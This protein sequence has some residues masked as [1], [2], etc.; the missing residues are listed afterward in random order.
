[1]AIVLALCGRAAALNKDQVLLLVNANMPESRKLAEFYCAARQIPQERIVALPL[2]I[3]EEIGYAAYEEQL[4]GPLREYI[5]ARR[6][7]NEIACIV[8]FHGVP[9][10]IGARTQ[11]P[12]ERQE[13]A[14]IQRQARALQPELASQVRDLET[15]AGGDPQFK[16]AGG[17][18][19]PEALLTRARAAALSLA[20]SPD[21]KANSQK[22][23]PAVRQLLGTAGVVSYFS[24]PDDVD[25]EGLRQQLVRSAREADAFRGNAEDAEARLRLRA[26][27]PRVFGQIELLRVLNEQ[28][29]LLTPGQ[30][31]AAVDSELALLLWPSYPRASWRGNPLHHRAA[32]RPAHPTLMVSRL[33]AP[34][35]Q[36]VRRVILDSIRVERD[37]LQGRLVLDTR[38]IAATGDNAKHGSFGWYDQSLRDL[39]ALVRQKTTLPMLIDDSPEVLA[40]GAAENAA[41]YCGWYSVRN[42]VPSARLNR[43]AVAFH[44]ASFELVSLRGPDEKGWCANLLNDGAA[45]TF[46]PVAEPYLL[47]FPQADEF[48][49]LLLT[50][51]LTLAEAYWKTTPTASWQMALIGDPLYT[52]YRVHPPL[53]AEDLPERLRGSLP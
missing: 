21:A 31:V 2:P 13:L 11:T 14:E 40:A 10:R 49:P 51:K 50:G 41:M 9:L 27:T 45:A 1:M 33:D 15:Q 36:T 34:T 38:N 8:T 3:T 20:R 18:D 44:V 7:G 23:L 52:P 24:G 6:L 26:M 37:G 4:A 46:G 29:A 22:L 28:I 25:A 48:V 53:R 43:G 30:T 35:A 19:A 17:G 12:R 42:Y 32:T 47:A 5:G 39:A 16:P